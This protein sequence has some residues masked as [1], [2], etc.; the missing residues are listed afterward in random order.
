MVCGGGGPVLP[1]AIEICDRAREMVTHLRQRDCDQARRA[2]WRLRDAVLRA[3]SPLMNALS[4]AI[5]TEGA[6]VCGA[7]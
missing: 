2:Q 5:R 6:P 7:L 3:N 4:D 1:E